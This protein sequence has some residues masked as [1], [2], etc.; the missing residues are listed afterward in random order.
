M[1]KIKDSSTNNQNR[2]FLTACDMTYALQLI[3]GRWKP[4]ILV[5]LE[6]QPLRYGELKKRIS[7]ITER[8]LTLQLRE[9]EEDNIV[10]RTVFPEVP[11][12]V[13]YELTEVGKEL[14]PV[15]LKLSDWGTIHRKAHT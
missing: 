12:R 10:K 15:L 14:I 7:H 11:P 1:S 2:K 8:M 3:G 9:M 4:L 13:E 6:K 5:N